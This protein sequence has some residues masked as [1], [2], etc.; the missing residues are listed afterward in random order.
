MRS[1]TSG[2]YVLVRSKKCWGQH[3]EGVSWKDKAGVV[4]MA[5]TNTTAVAEVG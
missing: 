3:Q 1:R 4:E 5:K 2:L